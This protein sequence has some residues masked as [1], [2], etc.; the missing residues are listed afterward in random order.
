MKTNSSQTNFR[1]LFKIPILRRGFI[2]TTLVALLTAWTLSAADKTLPSAMTG[3]F[4]GSAKIIVNWTKQK[5]LP[6]EVVIADDGSVTGK[7]GDATLDDGRLK[8]NRGAIGRKL[9][10]KTDYII[11]GQLSGP[12]I[13]AENIERKAVSIPLNFKGGA[14]SGGV[15]TSGSKIGGQSG[16]KLSASGLTLKPVSNP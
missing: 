10:I 15:H 12:V 4:K 8:K 16:M 7:I 13:K 1:S 5:Q 2:L 11:V 14:F 3:G 9:N 6:V